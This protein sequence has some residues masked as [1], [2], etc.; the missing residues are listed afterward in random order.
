MTGDQ[1]L[2]RI[3][4]AMVTA[5]ATLTAY[6]ATESVAVAVVVWIATMLA[7]VAIILLI[8]NGDL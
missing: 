8:E 4:F 3:A 5:G 7:A 1:W 6:V 2:N